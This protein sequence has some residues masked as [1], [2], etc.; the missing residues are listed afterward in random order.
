ME[1]L[2]ASDRPLSSVGALWVSLI[3]SY[4]MLAF[5]G[6]DLCEVQ[7][8]AYALRWLSMWCITTGGGPPWFLW[9]GTISLIEGV[10]P[11]AFGF[12]LGALR[13]GVSSLPIGRTE[14]HFLGTL[15]GQVS[16]DA[17]LG[18]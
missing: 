16:W 13:C 18:A 6:C 15:Y 2:L 4:D 12:A 17:S 11:H 7:C 9:S 1:Q 14:F 5:D 10:G 3:F 8:V